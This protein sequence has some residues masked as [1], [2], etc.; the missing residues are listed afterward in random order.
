MYLNN[1]LSNRSSQYFIIF[2]KAGLRPSI[3][4]KGAK[5]YNSLVLTLL[6]CVLLVFRRR[7]LLG[8][9]YITF[10]LEELQCTKPYPSENVL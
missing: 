1:D 3:K 9:D 8:N 4:Y 10:G 2:T 7:K 6:V 5:R